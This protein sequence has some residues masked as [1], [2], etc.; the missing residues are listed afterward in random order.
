MQLSL[1]NKRYNHPR[2]QSRGSLSKIYEMKWN[3]KYL[4]IFLKKEK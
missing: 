3:D 2:I 1:Q 4:S